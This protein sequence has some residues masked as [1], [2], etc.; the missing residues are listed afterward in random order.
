MDNIEDIELLNSEEAFDRELLLE[1]ENDFEIQLEKDENPQIENNDPPQKR[2]LKSER[3]EVY[4][5]PKNARIFGGRRSSGMSEPCRS[6]LGEGYGAC[7][8][9]WCFGHRQIFSRQSEQRLCK[10]DPRGRFS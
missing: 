3:R 2:K 1:Q 8:D 4:G 6:R 5:V 7:D 9:A 10:A